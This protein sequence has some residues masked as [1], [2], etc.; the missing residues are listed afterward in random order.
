MEVG[1]GET[2]GKI[3]PAILRQI[4][5]DIEGVIRKMSSMIDRQKLVSSEEQKVK[6]LNHIRGE[7]WR[8]GLLSR[9]INPSTLK[10]LI[11]TVTES[12]D[13]ANV[14]LLESVNLLKMLLD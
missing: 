14:S 11:P 5:D 10:G 7:K 2:K 12:V 13:D 9:D 6:Y 1:K 4:D 3:T 8:E